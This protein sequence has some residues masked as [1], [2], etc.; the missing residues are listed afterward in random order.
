MGGK[1]GSAAEAQVGL[2]SAQFQEKL[3]NA[4]REANEKTDAARCAAA[5]SLHKEAQARQAAFA[6]SDAARETLAK[7][8]RE[9]LR[10][11]SAD[12]ETR[13]RAAATAADERID[14]ANDAIKSLEHSLQGAVKEHL[15][16]TTS[17]RAQLKAERQMTEEREA[18]T[19]KKLAGVRDAI[20]TRLTLE[21]CDIRKGLGEVRKR[22]HDETTDIRA[23]LREKAGKKEVQ[24][25]GKASAEHCA[26]VSTAMD[27]HRMRLESSVTEFSTRYRETRHE[28]N[29]SRLRSQREAIALGGEVTQLRAACT[30]L[31]TGTVKALQILGLIV[32]EDEKATSA[33]GTPATDKPKGIEVED[34]LRWEKAGKSLALRVERSWHKQESAGNAT[35]LAMVERGFEDLTT[36]R[37]ILGADARYSPDI[38]TTMATPGA[39]T[40]ASPS[41]VGNASPQP[42]KGGIESANSTAASVGA[43]PGSPQKPSTAPAAAPQ[44][45]KDLRQK[46][47]ST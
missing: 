18:D 2:A 40:C 30:S 38:V 15:D 8:L 43:P 36:L 19:T 5:D 34:L 37:S 17:L 41:V 21:A 9:E 42:F 12:G 32:A 45:V 14:R 33:S 13:L 11:A 27:S 10:V 35:V 24:D 47:T 6:T 3:T 26:E 44:A 29:E 31:A 46:R 25:V 28:A 4:L 23:E 22:V 20:E 7:N 1:C 16:T 39:S